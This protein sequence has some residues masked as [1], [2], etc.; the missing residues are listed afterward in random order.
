MLL[1][2]QKVMNNGGMALVHMN[3]HAV[4]VFWVY[5]AIT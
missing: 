2:A 5:G 4:P 3:A 1:P